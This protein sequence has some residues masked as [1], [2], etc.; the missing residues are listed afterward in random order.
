MGSSIK[1]R[2]SCEELL[3]I[4]NWRDY[5]S[6]RMTKKKLSNHSFLHSFLIK[7]ENGITL[8]RG[9]KYP[10]DTCEWLPKEGIELLASNVD[11]N[12]VIPVAPMRIEKL[13]LDAVYMGVV[14]KYI[15]FLCDEEKMYVTSSWE[16]LKVKLENL[17]KKKNLTKMS[18]LKFPKQERS[19]S[20][21][22]R[23]NS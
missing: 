17:P 15:P 21:N 6:P 10:Q 9:K 7:K 18:L 13:N 5:I 3:F 4:W 23:H 1:P 19:T 12:S 11:L 8:L 14:T 16:R 2:P 20:T 22:V